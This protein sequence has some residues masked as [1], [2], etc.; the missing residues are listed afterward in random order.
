MKKWKRL[1]ALGLAV[2][3][4]C[5]VLSGCG[6]NAQNGEETLSVC[7]GEAPVTFDPI[8]AEE[9][10]D[11]TIL[12]HLYENLMRVTMDNEGQLTVTEGAAKS[13]SVE[14]NADGTVTYTFHLRDAKWSDGVPVRAGDFVYA[15]Q[16]LANK[17]SNSPYA[18]LLSI[19]CGY[20]EAR[21]S[22]DMSQLAVTAKSSNT[23][24]VTLN[25]YYDWFL[26]E[27]CTSPV[28]SPLRQDVVKKLKEA[29]E[30][31]NPDGMDGER[32]W[33]N[34]T[35]LV[36]N[37]PFTVTERE[38]NQALRLSSNKY[39]DRKRSGPEK[40]EFRFGDAE[41]A[42]TLY[43]TNEVD[44]IWP[45]TEAWMA[46]LQETDATWTADPELATHAVLFNYERLTDENVRRALSLAIDREAIAEIA[47]VTAQAATGLVPPGVP[48][49]TGDFR[50]MGGALLDNDPE[51]Y[52]DRCAQAVALLESSGYESGASLGEL[53][54]LYVDEEH[55]G[56]VAEAL[57]ASWKE[58][59]GTKITPKAM[60]RT[61]LAAALRSGEYVLAEMEVKAVCN[62]AECFL[63]D[64]TTGSS[65][66]FLH[67]GNSAYDTLMAII[68]SAADGSAR[69]GCLH[70]A[71]D[72]L[73]N[74]D[75]ALAP[76]HT[77][78]TAWTMRENYA[79]VIR[80]TRGWFDF[81]NVYQKPAV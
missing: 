68:A 54:Y 14:E 61:E 31:R 47:G 39:Y 23:L 33:S 60:T 34:P 63:M 30:Q 66:N 56:A 9:P 29:V 42:K 12:A 32:W 75:C 38:G 5:S 7:V 69:M 62:D 11:Q 8:Y 44:V 37:G 53:E 25:G 4:S 36:T 15:W 51:T 77:C 20:Q 41:T 70:D 55:N 79:G 13:V 65:N 1:C 21:A 24:V 67:Y 28:T 46:S 26:R 16:R 27:V 48:E 50:E 73:L 19:V 35:L 72:L 10:G 45:L 78:G 59:L 71:E 58:I 76:L 57:C 52:A 3:M 18:S 80:D 64:F 49:G 6:K 17:S 43:E 2:I 22:G 81:S 40:L 74:I